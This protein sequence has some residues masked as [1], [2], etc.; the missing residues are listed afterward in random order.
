MGFGQRGRRLLVRR[1]TGTM[2]YTLH[3]VIRDVVHHEAQ[4][5]L[6]HAWQGS[7]RRQLFERDRGVCQQCHFDA[8]SLFLRVAALQSPQAAHAHRHTLNDTHTEG[9]TFTTCPDAHATNVRVRHECT[10][11]RARKA[12]FPLQARMQALLESHYSTLGDRIKRMLND[13]KAGDFW[14]ADHVVAVAEGGGESDLQNFQTL[15]VPC[16]AKK[17]RAQKERS[18]TEKRKKAAEG[19]ADLRSFF[20]APRV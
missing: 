15:C 7:A 16:H 9:L 20:K 1:V 6:V 17:S 10:W 12:R 5:L 14:E 13:P 18:K 4:R 2:P 11:A 19:T 3:C 8:H